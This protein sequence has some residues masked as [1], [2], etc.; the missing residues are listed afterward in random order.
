MQLP[1]IVPLERHWDSNTS[2]TLIEA[3]PFLFEKGYDTLCLEYPNDDDVCKV[4]NCIQETITLGESLTRQAAEIFKKKGIKISSL[5]S[6]DATL[7]KFL[8]WLYVSSKN[9]D[10]MA[11]HIR[12]LDG[13]KQKLE[14]VKLALSMKLNIQS[15][16]LSYQQ[17][18]ILSYPEV[19]SNDRG[20]VV[21]ALDN[22]RIA[23]FMNNLLTQW[24]AGKNI[25][26]PVG[27]FH[28]KRLVEEF[29][30]H[31]LLQDVIFIRPFTP[32][33]YSFNVKDSE[34]VPVSLSQYP[35]LTLIEQEIWETE[36]IKTCID[37]LL[38][39]IDAK[40]EIGFR[41]PDTTTTRLLQLATALPFEAY[42]VP[43]KK[44]DCYY[45]TKGKSVDDIEKCF[46]SLI[47]QKINYRHTFFQGSEAYCV[48]SVNIENVAD[49]IMQLRGFRQ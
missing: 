35:T 11:L 25:I 45:F 28:Y 4:V 8:L 2:K 10:G 18:K 12:E 33:D 31:G 21:N 14:L 5:S 24:Y 49:K 44:V 38:N 7:L 1:I 15:V 43:S 19:S 27:V 46:S 40:K 17:I 22:N 26:F 32:H 37:S 29:H 20:D 23:S 30:K 39:A 34:I 9:F 48:P 3:L 13:N 16:D 6:L 36:D 47:K 42:T 41:I